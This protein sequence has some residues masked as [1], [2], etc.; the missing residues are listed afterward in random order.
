MRKK[1]VVSV[2][3]CCLYIGS[4]QAQSL[5]QKQFLSHLDSFA[6]K[7]LERIPVIPAISITIADEKGPV[8]IKAYGTANKTTGEK[9]DVNTEFYIASTTKSFMGLAA[10][11][12]DYEK[13]ILLD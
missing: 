1:M 9:A 13:K 4:L 11:L 7:L 10:A 5:N 12:L 8:F 6:T 3:A 2:I